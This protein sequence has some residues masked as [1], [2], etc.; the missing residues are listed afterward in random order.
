TTATEATLYTYS[1]TFS[2]PDGPAGAWSL[3]AGHTCGGSIVAG[4][5]VFTFTPAGPTP[6]ASCVVAVRYCDGATPALCATQSTTV[7]ITAV[8]D[9]GAFTSTAPPG[10]TEDTPYSYLPTVADPDG[11]PGGTWSVGPADTCAATIDAMT[12]AYTFT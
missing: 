4:S 2:D 5:G 9:P 7:T 1:A 8:N 12:G 10:A 3:A 6:P 11:P